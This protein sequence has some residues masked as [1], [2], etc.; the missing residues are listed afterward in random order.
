M[1][2]PNKMAHMPWIKE[3]T[4]SPM[5]PERIDTP[6]HHVGPK[7]KLKQYF[8]TYLG[9]IV[10]VAYGIVS[11][12]ITVFNKAVL[13]HY[14]FNYS[15]TLSLG[16]GLCSLAFLYILRSYGKVFFP[17]PGWKTAIEVRYS[18][19]IEFAADSN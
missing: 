14:Q 16:Q 8:Q 5:M 6:K 3:G 15:N 7:P 17:N 2:A 18:T 13:T 11:V 1:F 10:A 12:S 4:R 9:L 19:Y